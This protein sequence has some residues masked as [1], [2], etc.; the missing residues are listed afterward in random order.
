[1]VA[2]MGY[3]TFVFFGLMCVIG[4]AFVYVLVPETKNLTL[5]EMDE[6]FGDE[7]GNAI[8]DRNRL[9]NIYT[10]LG[11]ITSEDSSLADGVEKT[12]ASHEHQVVYETGKVAD[13]V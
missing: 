6:V 1:M 2:A 4:A 5:E 7:A 13:G 3:G 12:S 10:E 11:L 8:E 9:M